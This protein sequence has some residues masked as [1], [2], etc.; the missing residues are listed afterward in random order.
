MPSSTL[1]NSTLPSSTLPNSTLPNAIRR[2]R[3][4][5]LAGGLAG[6]LALTG[7]A[8]AADPASSS[9]GAAT[10]AAAVTVTDP[11]VKAADADMTG[12]FAVLA[13]AGNTDA[14]LTGASTSVA[15]MVELHRMT[16]SAGAQ[17][18]QEID[19]G[20]AVPAGG[21][22]TLAPGGLHLMFMD[23]AGPL[24]P[25]DTVGV[26]LEFADGSTSEVQFEVKAYTGANETYAPEDHSG[27]DMSD[28]SGHDH[29]SESE[30]GSEG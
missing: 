15:G 20:I 7:C 25:G 8:A 4:A 27:M 22:T 5:L 11:W 14:E 21:G 10:Q 13:N 30:Q 2:P 3:F 23:L 12:A 24:E 28:E 18:M 1:P 17:R 19:G 9:A 29:A 6:A 16:G 26:T